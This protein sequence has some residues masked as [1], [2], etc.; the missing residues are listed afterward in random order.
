MCWWVGQEGGNIMQVFI[1]ARAYAQVHVHVQ[2]ASPWS[3]PVLL[4]CPPSLPASQEVAQG[5]VSPE[6]KCLGQDIFREKRQRGRG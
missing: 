4:P 6:G 5:V 2:A 1:F 3:H